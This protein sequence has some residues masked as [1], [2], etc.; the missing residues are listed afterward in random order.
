MAN[1]YTNYDEIGEGIHWPGFSI[2]VPILVFSRFLPMS[3]VDF[4]CILMLE[5]KKT[6][7]MDIAL[8]KRDRS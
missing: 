4:W 1:D 6:R 8:S 3:E 7:E 2:V 5:V